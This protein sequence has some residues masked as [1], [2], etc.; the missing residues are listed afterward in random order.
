MNK[1]KKIVSLFFVFLILSLCGNLCAKERKM[2][3][4]CF[5]GGLSFLDGGNAPLGAVSLGIYYKVI[6]IEV[7]G[8]IL[9]GAQVIGGNLV[10]GPFDNQS[11]IPYATGGIWTTTY[12]G[13]GF[14]FGGGIKIRLSEGFAFRSEYR[15]YFFS[16]TDWGLNVIV[17]GISLFF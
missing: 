9:G 16:D 10:A 2:G 5:A 8:A 12:G 14:N 6:G 1:G 3:E 4:I 15:R 13:F 7:N 11:L 17:G